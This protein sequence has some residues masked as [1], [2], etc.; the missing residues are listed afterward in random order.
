VLRAHDLQLSERRLRPW[1]RGEHGCKCA[2]CA[3]ADGRECRRPRRSRV[4]IEHG[5]GD[6]DGD[7]REQ[8]GRVQR[9]DQYQR[10]EHELSRRHSDRLQR[11][12]LQGFAR[13]VFGQHVVGNARQRRRL[14][15]ARGHRCACYRNGQQRAGVRRERRRPRPPPATTWSMQIW[16]DTWV[17]MP[18]GIARAL[19]EA[20]FPRPPS[21]LRDRCRQTSE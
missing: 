20:G 6:L 3:L 1:Q 10:C 7:V 15:R 2:H 19:P 21:R 4:L 18:Y 16:S 11:R 14:G 8:L 5:D 9:T 17:A 12:R 13:A